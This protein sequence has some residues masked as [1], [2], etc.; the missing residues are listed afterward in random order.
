M[1]GFATKLGF[2]SHHY[3]KN[4]TSPLPNYA[5]SNSF[6]QANC[7]LTLYPFNGFRLAIIVSVRFSRI[8]MKPH[9]QPFHATC[10]CV[11]E[12]PGSRREP[13]TVIEY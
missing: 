5:L 11:G 4:K 8:Y 2:W 6:D 12:G 10:D 13:H 9:Y 3:R 1:A 7:A